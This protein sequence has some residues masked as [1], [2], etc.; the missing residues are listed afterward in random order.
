MPSFDVVS[1]V[2]IHVFTNAVDQ[3]GR[4]IANRFDFK[5]VDAGFERKDRVVTL[6]AESEFQ[7]QQM[8]DVLRT[9]VAK[10]GIDA[11]AMKEADVQGGGRIVKQEITMRHGIEIELARQVV[12]L[13]KESKIKVQ[14]SI[15]G[16]QVRVS[17][18]KRDEL[19]ETI[20]MLRKQELEAPLQFQNFRD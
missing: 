17:G 18:K 20:A 11:R 1:E 19:Q 15:Q 9:S 6:H 14:A 5:G 4:L 12:K 7:I 10:C 13:I 2:D 8:R 16:D 3:A